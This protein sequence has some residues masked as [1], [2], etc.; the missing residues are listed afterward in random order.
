MLHINKQNITQLV[1]AF[2]SLLIL[3]CCHKRVKENDSTSI[4]LAYLD[5]NVTQKKVDIRVY[6][7]LPPP[8]LKESVNN[9]GEVKNDS[10]IKNLVPLR[11]FI[12]DSIRY[13]RNFI[14]PKKDFKDF[15][16]TKKS[17]ENAVFLNIKSLKERKG[18]VLES[19]NYV[20][21]SK[22]YPEIYLDDN[23]G[24]LISF[25]NLFVSQDGKKAYFEVIYFKNRLNTQKSTIKAEFKKGKW[26]F[27]SEMISIS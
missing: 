2:L 18:I 1:F 8:E 14:P 25:E 12:N 15:S 6:N 16:F 19:I 3:L 22:L 26:V 27:K 20:E 17:I 4:I 13:S 11:I 7:P 24:W 10:I 21:F 23:Y 5:S 9:G